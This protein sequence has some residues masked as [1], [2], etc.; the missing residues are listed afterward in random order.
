LSAAG[1]RRWRSPDAA[2]H[3]QPDLTQ[4]LL[5]DAAGRALAA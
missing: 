3:L 2:I 5:F 4:A 1:A